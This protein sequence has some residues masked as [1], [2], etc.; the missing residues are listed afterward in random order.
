MF[1][2][3][4]FIRGVA[5]T[6]DVTE[7]LLNMVPLTGTTSGNELFL[8]VEKSLKKFNVDWS[9]LVSVSTDGNSMMVGVK[10]LVTKLKSRVSGLCKDTELKSVNGLILQESLCAKK[11]KMDHVM[12]IVIYTIIWIRSHG[13]N[14]RKFRALFNELDAIWKA[15]LLHGT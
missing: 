10:Q 12:D 4:V 6:F 1:Q 7:E 3:A 9:K 5:E 8:C 14:H 13:S 15:V 2:L 11:L